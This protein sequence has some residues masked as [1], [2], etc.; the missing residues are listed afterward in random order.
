MDQ[1]YLDWV[2]EWVDDCESLCE[3]YTYFM[4]STFPE[5]TRVFG[6][7]YFSNEIGALSS[8]LFEYH[9]WCITADGE[10]VDPTAQQFEEEYYPTPW[11]YIGQVRRPELHT[12]S[13]HEK[14]CVACIEEK[15]NA[16]YYRVT[17]ENPRMGQ[18][19]RLVGR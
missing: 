11:K 15:E 4:Q 9:W 12:D 2:E 13:E 10:I 19:E 18:P 5:L 8:P 3:E 1:K 14:F 7:L 17:A 6:K 16:N